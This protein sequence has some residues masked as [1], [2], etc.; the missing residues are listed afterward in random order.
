M[1]SEISFADCLACPCTRSDDDPVA[2]ACFQF[3][4]YSNMTVF[5][6]MCF[7]VGLEFFSPPPTRAQHRGVEHVYPGI[8]A[9]RVPS[10]AH[11]ASGM[12]LILFLRYP[13][14]C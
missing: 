6:K 7:N 1:K 14:M 9:Q 4:V 5:S 13:D 12:S 11:H 3:R 8:F 2:P 10:L